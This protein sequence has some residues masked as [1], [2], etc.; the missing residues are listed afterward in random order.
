MVRQPIRRPQLRSQLFAF[1]TVSL[2]SLIFIG[3]QKTL[4][5]LRLP[6]GGF[7]IIPTP[8]KS[9]VESRSLFAPAPPDL[10]VS[11]DGQIR[12]INPHLHSVTGVDSIEVQRINPTDTG[13]MPAGGV[14]NSIY[15]DDGRQYNFYQGPGIQGG[16]YQYRARFNY[17]DSFGVAQ[18]GPW[19]TVAVV[20][21]A[22]GPVAPFDPSEPGNGCH[23]FDPSKGAGNGDCN[24]EGTAAD[25]V[26][27]ATGFETYNPKPDLP[28]YN[29]I[30]LPV[31]FQRTYFSLSSLQSELT[32][33]LPIGWSHNYDVSAKFDPTS[34]GW[35]NVQ[36]RLP[37]GRSIWLE[38]VLNAGT[39]TGAFVRPA[40]TPFIVTGVPSTTQV[41]A[42]TSL[43]VKWVG[44]TTWTLSLPTTTTLRLSR[45]ASKTGQYL[46]LAWTG[47]KLYTISNQSATVLLS[48]FYSGGVGL[49]TESRD[50]YSR[51][52]YYGY[53]SSFRLT[54][55]SQV[56]PTGTASPATKAVYGYSLTSGSGIG[57]LSSI[58]VPSPVGGSA[59]STTIINYDAATSKVTGLVDANG[60]GEFYTYGT[61]ST[62][63]QRKDPLSVVQLQ[64]TQKWDSQLRGTGII[65]ASAHAT[66]IEYLDGSNPSKGTRLT[67]R[68]GRITLMGY[69]SFGNP[70]SITTPRSVTTVMSYDYSVWP[71]GRISQSQ[72]ASDSPAT[73]LYFANGM[74]NS[75]TTAKPGATTGTVT[76][77][78][79]Y[80]SLGNILTV[81]APA[82]NA[83][84]APTMT[85]NYTSDGVF[86]Q[87][88]TVGQVLTVTDPNGNVNH[89]RYD[90]QG[91]VMTSTD[92]LGIQT[93]YTYNIVDQPLQVTLPSTG[94]TGAGHGTVVNAFL[95]PGG[96]MSS[97]TNFNESGTQVK[98][99]FTT[100]GS[101]GEVLN[102]F[103]NTQL[104]TYTYD[105]LY[106]IK[107][108]VDGNS[109]ATQYIYDSV[110][111]L[112]QVT[113]P[114]SGVEQYT[115]YDGEGSG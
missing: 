49:L 65:D 85:Y 36:L 50:L 30:G 45:I 3:G 55:V 79:T 47:D 80:D 10:S 108:L 69:D 23:G 1:L 90:S 113:Y 109:N 87:S 98:Q 92:P 59:T 105:A 27:L 37:S 40:G 101:E 28:I 26:N 97:T 96:P 7:G 24:S 61:N 106:R 68:D 6:F 73:F 15:F 75:V 12:N 44:E 8:L 111:R 2:C 32:P 4:G 17:Y 53:D 33:G 5:N 110:G 62:I 74:L 51:S 102:V 77:T 107:T 22:D 89:A 39:A 103:G 91:R 48:L 84:A 104:V 83:S 72:R 81:V 9:S 58:T 19:A 41:G 13:W 11:L 14:P 34:G 18:N 21:T 63:V 70:S 52:T 99:T 82:N 46:D 78:F 100:Y 114:A 16:L 112:S 86:T 29:P 95:W 60:N 35:G 31:V 25:P 54:S 43:T 71:T 38:P 42:W 57:L 93:T 115:S 56:V 94:Q 64:Y 76:T 67:D 66:T 88:A 20:W